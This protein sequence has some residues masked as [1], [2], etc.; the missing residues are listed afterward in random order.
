[1]AGTY[2]CVGG[3]GGCD[4]GGNQGA[5]GKEFYYR[6][7]QAALLLILEHLPGPYCKEWP[8]TELFLGAC[9]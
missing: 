6:G 8:K 7:G 9:G 1:M 5:K 3:N 4:G 2:G